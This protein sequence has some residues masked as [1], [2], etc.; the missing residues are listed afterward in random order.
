MTTEEHNSTTETATDARQSSNDSDLAQKLSIIRNG[1]NRQAA[2]ADHE[3]EKDLYQI[4]SLRLAETQRHLEAMEIARDPHSEF[5][6]EV[7]LNALDE[8]LVPA[9]E[10]V[11]LEIPDET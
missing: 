11:T 7:I 2:A 10:G 6:F 3:K 9:S 4:L 5:S 1:I 8:E